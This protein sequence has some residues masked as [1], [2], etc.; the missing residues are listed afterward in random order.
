MKAH[1]HFGN[2][3]V[4][5]QRG[6]EDTFESR[7]PQN[8]LTDKLGHRKWTPATFG[9]FANNFTY[10]ETAGEMTISTNYQNLSPDVQSSGVI[11]T[12]LSRFSVSL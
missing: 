3:E 4:S 6:F 8:A 5:L 11:S 1:Y 12:D 2:T 7:R 10:G 9:R